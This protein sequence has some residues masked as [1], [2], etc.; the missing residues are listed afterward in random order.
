MGLL[1]WRRRFAAN[2]DL[3]ILWHG[4]QPLTIDAR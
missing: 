3:S 4:A 1:M 2:C